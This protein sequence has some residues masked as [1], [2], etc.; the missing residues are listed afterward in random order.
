MAEKLDSFELY[1]KEIYL[2]SILKHNTHN[3]IS[4]ENYVSFP[5]FSYL[6]FFPNSTDINEVLQN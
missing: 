1:L 5:L 2:T 3:N 4:H 6:I